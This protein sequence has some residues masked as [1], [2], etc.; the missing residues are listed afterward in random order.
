[1]PG[2]AF[3]I[4]CLSK[5]FQRRRLANSRYSLRAFSKSLG[6]DIGVISRTLSGKRGLSVRLADRIAQKLELSAGE[7]R[8]FLDSAGQAKL[9][10]DLSRIP[11]SPALE[12]ECFYRVANDEFRVIADWY[13]YAILEMTFVSPRGL[14][15]TQIARGLGISAAEA[16]AAVDRLLSVGL[17]HREGRR[18]TK[19]K[20]NITTGDK[21][22]SSVALRRHQRQMLQH[23]LV[24]LDRDPIEDRN[25]TSMT[26]AIDPA[27]LMTARVRI[28]KFTEELCRH[29]E[30]PK[31]KRVYQLQVSLFPLQR[32]EVPQL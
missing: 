7:R 5:E 19:T 17:L 30:G 25:S 29:L 28:E 15:A 6:V 8:T 3:H 18:L 23:A 9:H 27:K 12:E 11:H 20:A 21:S 24:S 26:M 31:R 4:D 13:H 10:R 2:D 14:T 16:R 22:V 1:M 32:K